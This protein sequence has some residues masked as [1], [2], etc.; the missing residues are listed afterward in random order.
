MEYIHDLIDIR[1]VDQ[2]V[3]DVAMD[4]LTTT[5]GIYR[6]KLFHFFSSASMRA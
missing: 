3:A 4:K 1:E 5:A 2:H 6:M